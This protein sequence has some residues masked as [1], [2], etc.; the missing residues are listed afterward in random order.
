MISKKFYHKGFHYDNHGVAGIVVAMLLI[1]LFISALAFVQT[2]YVPQWMTEKEAEHM[3]QVANQ[4]S[5]FKFSVDTLAVVEKQYS[6]IST[7]VTLGNKELPFLSSSRSYGSL[8]I[9]PYNFKIEIVGYDDVSHMYDL[10][11][12]SYTSTNVYFLNQV[13]AYETG[14]VI[15]SQ[16]TGDVVVIQP[17]IFV[18]DGKDLSIDLIKLN[19]IGGKNTASGYG[20]YPIQAKFSKSYAETIPG[21]KEIIIHSSYTNAWGSFF[22]NL[23]SSFNGD[24]IQVAPDQVTITFD[25]GYQPNLS[26]KIIDI[27]L[28]VAPGWVE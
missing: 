9:N 10:G 28:Q 7:P 3:E 12:L 4:F 26:L 23:L 21:V 15:L 18:I 25:P 13:Y 1:G 2:V 14:A 22:K 6:P 19:E 24:S 11:S 20:I 8:F 17:S 5:Q 16:Q 27:D